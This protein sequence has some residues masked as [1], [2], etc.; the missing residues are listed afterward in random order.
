MQVHPIM[1]KC[2]INMIKLIMVV[3]ITFNISAHVPDMMG[4]PQYPIFRCNSYACGPIDY[5]WMRYFLSSAYFFTFCVVIIFHGMSIYN[6]VSIM[7]LLNMI[8]VTAMYMIDKTPIIKHYMECPEI[9]KEDIPGRCVPTSPYS[10]KW[11]TD[12]NY[13]PPTIPF[14]HC[15]NINEINQMISTIITGILIVSMVFTI[16]RY[17]NNI[18]YELDDEDLTVKNEE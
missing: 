18:L 6:K 10:C 17:I 5:N 4:L 8:L 2:M 9:Y 12:K 14:Y 16:M 13:I 7:I 3:I 11:E 1:Q 15:K